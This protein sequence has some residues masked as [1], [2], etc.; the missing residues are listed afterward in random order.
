MS[1]S[2]VLF[3]GSLTEPPRMRAVPSIRGSSWS[4]CRKITIPFESSMRLGCCGWKERSGGIGIC[5]QVVV[6]AAA[7]LAGAIAE[8]VSRRHTSIRFIVP[9]PDPPEHF[10]VHF[11]ESLQPPVHSRSL[12]Q[13]GLCRR[14]LHSLH[15]LY[16]PWSRHRY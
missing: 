6:C 14:K 13:C 10:L 16:L 15:A 8:A 5:F 3:A 12:P 9:L 1:T 4:S 7:C 2:P 11:R